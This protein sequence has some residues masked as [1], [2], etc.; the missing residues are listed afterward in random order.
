MHS[1]P[2]H[3]ATSPAT[4]LTSCCSLLTGHVL[5]GIR[6]QLWQEA[7]VPGKGWPQQPQAYEGTVKSMQSSAVGL[8]VATTQKPHAQPAHLFLP[9]IDP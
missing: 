3:R 6:Q 2:C 4:L 8:L 5:A 7:T 1:M 9:A